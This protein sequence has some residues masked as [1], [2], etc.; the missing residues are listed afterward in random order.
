MA[1]RQFDSAST[2]AFSTRFTSISLRFAGL[3]APLFDRLQNAPVILG[4][5]TVVAGVGVTH[6]RYPVRAR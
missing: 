6:L 2:P 5:P 4:N 3:W 1:A